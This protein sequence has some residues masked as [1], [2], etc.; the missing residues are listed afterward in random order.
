MNM[1]IGFIGLGHMGSAI[2]RNLLKG[3]HELI[4]W[5]RSPEPVKALAQAGARAAEAPV[6]VFAAAEV[7]F[8]MLADD[9]VVE[10]VVLN[11]GAL[12]AAKPGAIHVNVATISVALADRL[13]RLH[14]DRGLSYVA[15]PVLG[16]PDVAAAGNLI[17]LAAGET[18]AVDR[19]R[20]LLA[21][22]ARRIFP[23]GEQSSRANV[24]KLACNFALAAMLETLGEAGALAATNGVAPETLFEVM[25][26]TVFPAYKTYAPLITERRFRPASFALPLGFKDVRL[27]LQAAEAKH[28]PMPIASV[29]HDQFLAAIAHGD[30]ELDWSALSMV[31]FRAAGLAA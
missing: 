28:A 17:V 7:V 29:L 16:R 27:A 19:V 11:S 2:A 21:L 18:V 23:M 1:K 26:E 12:D 10:S 24:V 22:F 14:R 25:T 8:S 6:D 15:A 13:E 9:A 4:A 30:S 3:G 5:N 31:A 20:P